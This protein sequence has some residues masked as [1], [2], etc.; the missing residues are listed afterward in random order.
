MTLMCGYVA[1]A[2][3]TYTYVS[4][5]DQ[6]ANQVADSVAAKYEADDSLTGSFLHCLVT[7][8]QHMYL[9]VSQ[10]GK[11]K[12]KGFAQQFFPPDAG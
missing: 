4:S 6:R 10:I 2:T 8:I 9:H 12:K 5:Q 1:S 11:K 3:T 7:H